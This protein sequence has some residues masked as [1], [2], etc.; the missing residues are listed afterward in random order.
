MR[1][2][3]GL[4]CLAGVLGMGLVPPLAM[5]QERVKL[6]DPLLG[7][8]GGGNTVPGAGVPSA[9]SRSAPIRPMA[10]PAAMI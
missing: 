7:V 10:R 4:M 2:V 9:S 8:D 6:V 1:G 3:Q 5:A